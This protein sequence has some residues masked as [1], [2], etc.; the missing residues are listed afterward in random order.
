[1]RPSPLSCLL[2]LCFPPN[3]RAEAPL[4]HHQASTL[5]P[6]LLVRV[7]K[8]QGHTK[9]AVL[10]SG[11][12]APSPLKRHNLTEV[13]SC[14]GAFP[15]PSP[16]DGSWVRYF[17]RRTPYPVDSGPAVAELLGALGPSIPTSVLLPALSYVGPE[18]SVISRKRERT[19]LKAG[20]VRRPPGGFSI[21][22]SVSLSL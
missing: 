4:S 3:F 13:P 5:R 20:C 6:D 14:R 11:C 2:L 21:S 15:R 17:Q 10:V 18:G 9:Q 16:S 7:P 19:T 22:L 1:M 8:A 12:L